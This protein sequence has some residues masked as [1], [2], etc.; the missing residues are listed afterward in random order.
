LALKFANTPSE[1]DPPP[2][3]LPG[4]RVG[5]KTG[6]IV[7][8]RSITGGRVSAADVDSVV[9]CSAAGAVGCP[10]INCCLSS[11]SFSSSLSDPS[12]SKVSARFWSTA[13]EWDSLARCREVGEEARDRKD[14]GGEFGTKGVLGVSSSFADICR[15][16]VSIIVVF[17]R[18][19]EA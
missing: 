13:A 3:T 11:P 4:V 12:A 9:V 10:R 15:P 7:G 19:Q 5:A 14:G 6:K 8:L 17:M 2:Y 1:P 18:G 16:F